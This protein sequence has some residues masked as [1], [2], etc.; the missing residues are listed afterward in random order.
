[1]LLN[2]GR[3]QFEPFSIDTI[4]TEGCRPNRLCS[5]SAISV[6]T[7]GR[8]VLHSAHCNGDC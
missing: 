1:M 4:R 6:S 3:S 8:S 5:V 7:T 2:N